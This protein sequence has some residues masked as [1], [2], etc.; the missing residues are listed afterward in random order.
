[1]SWQYSHKS[2]FHQIFNLFIAFGT[3]QYELFIIMIYAR[4]RSLFNH[5]LLCPSLNI[6]KNVSINPLFKYLII[7]SNIDLW[8]YS[9]YF[10][11]E[12][13]FKQSYIRK[14]ISYDLPRTIKKIT[15]EHHFQ[16]KTW[17]TK[18]STKKSQEESAAKNNNFSRDDFSSKLVATF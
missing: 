9:K 12:C 18:I 7:H 2:S 5:I 14:D 16:E 11:L 10:K 4:Q 13:F 8:I 1:M 15:N 17:E 6:Y 3:P